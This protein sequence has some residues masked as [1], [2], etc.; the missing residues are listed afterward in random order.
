MND[1]SNDLKNIAHGTANAVMRA[2][3]IIKNIKLILLQAKWILIALIIL[4]LLL[5]LVGAGSFLLSGGGSLTGSS[6]NKVT[7]VSTGQL[8]VNA[9][10]LKLKPLVEKYANEHG[11][12]QYVNFILALIMQESGGRGSDP[13]QSSESLCG[14]RGCITDVEA[15]VR[16][17][18][19]HFKSV[20]EKANYDIHLTLQSYNFGAGF[21]PYVMKRGGKYT[22]ELAIEFSQYMYQLEKSRGNGHQFK[23]SRAESKQYQ[24]CYGDI[25]YVDAV[26]KYAGGIAEA[27]PVTG[28]NVNEGN[29]SD[30]AKKVAEAGFKYIG[31]S[32]YVFGGG[33][34]K[35]DIDNGIFDCSSFVYW[36][37]KEAGVNIGSG[38]NTDT[39]KKLGKKVSI[40]EIQ[41]GDI[42]FW[43]TYKKDG[44][45]GIYIG[46]GEWIGSQSSTGVAI[47]KLDKKYY[48]DRFKG[49]VRRLL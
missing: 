48:Q 15:S 4:I 37:F 45:V 44:H 41:V 36:A 32:V 25:L 18:V 28:G 26:L 16:Q 6:S 27:V 9:E 34:S 24:A 20:L 22:L 3:Y 47:V 43:D 29:V 35:Y 17:G 10:T 5:I 31:N 33:R 2:I 46:N 14:Y 23:C 11:I 12:G 40:D 42:I 21:I 1:V 30:V 8:Q 19:K 38:G 39:L 13:M 49:H 7:Y